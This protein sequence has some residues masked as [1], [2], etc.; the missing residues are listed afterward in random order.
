M[1]ISKEKLQYAT[2]AAK[3]AIIGVENPFLHQIWQK[4]V[5]NV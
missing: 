1:K 3:T 5:L 2:L 4:T